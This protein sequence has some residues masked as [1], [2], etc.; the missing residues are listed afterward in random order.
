MALKKTGDEIKLQ[1]IVWGWGQGIN[2][3]QW[4]ATAIV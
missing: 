1:L 3:R 2:G 4:D